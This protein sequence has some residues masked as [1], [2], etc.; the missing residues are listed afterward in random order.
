MEQNI[1]S[2][3]FDFMAIAFGCFRCI[4]RQL[5]ANTINIIILSNQNFT[6]SMNIHLFT[7]ILQKR[8]IDLL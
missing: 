4:Y 8:Y 3:A 7:L 6:I 5:H 1:S 2:T